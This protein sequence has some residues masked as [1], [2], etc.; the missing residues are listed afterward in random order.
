MTELSLIVATVGRDWQLKRLLD[1]LAAQTAIN[2]EVIIVDQNADDRV[3]LVLKREYPFP[4]IYTQSGLG[5]SRARNVG[6]A[7]ARGEVLGFPDD[8]C[9]YESSVTGRVGDAFRDPAV[10]VFTGRLRDPD[11]EKDRYAFASEPLEIAGYNVRW[12]VT[13]PAMFIRRSM[14]LREQ[15]FDERIGPGAGTIWGGME[16]HDLVAR[17]IRAG[18]RGRY[19][20][21]L[22]IYHPATDSVTVQKAHAYGGGQGFINAL[23]PEVPPG[24]LGGMLRSLAGWAY[25]QATF[26]RGRAAVNAAAFSGRLRGYL[27]ARSDQT[28]C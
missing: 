10:E 15:G 24:L 28:D 25:H 5:A 17:C 2:F 18:T 12:C 14:F 13:A 6:A 21:S 20:P 16:E 26:R 7:K 1:S 19:D 3:R 22:V 8:D 4:V 9:W 27:Q 23:Y 11:R